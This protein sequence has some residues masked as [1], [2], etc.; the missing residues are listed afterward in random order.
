[1]EA[2]SLAIALPSQ[3]QLSRALQTAPDDEAG[4]STSAIPTTPSGLTL[5]DVL[6]QLRHVNAGVRK[7]SLAHLREV[8]TAGVNHGVKLGER[9]GE[10]AKV[11]RGVGALVADDVSFPGNVGR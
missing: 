4:P 6:I 5:E 1:V 9:H 3:K 11:M 2:N 10:V 7:E 8:L